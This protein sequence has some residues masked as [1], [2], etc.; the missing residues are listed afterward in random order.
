MQAQTKFNIMKKI[1]LVIF[2]L[3]SY[4]NSTSHITARKKITNVFVDKNYLLVKNLIAKFPLSKNFIQKTINI[5]DS[6]NL[7]PEWLLTVFAIET[8][9]TFNP[10][11]QNKLSRATGLIQFLPSTLKTYGY[12]INELKE[13]SDIDQ[14]DLILEY[15]K[16][17]IKWKGKIKSLEDAYFAV[18]APSLVNKNIYHPVYHS[19]TLAYLYNKSNDLDKNGVVIKKEISYKV[20]KKFNKYFKKII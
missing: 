6:L 17:I 11:I 3:C 19:G 1:I 8:G 13:M 7:K 18:H 4:L 14:L 12:T 9:D 5:S 15:Y 16:R 10:A 20:I 2:L